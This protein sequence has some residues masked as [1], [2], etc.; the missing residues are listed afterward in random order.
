VDSAIKAD[1]R[2]GAAIWWENAALREAAFGN[3][4]EALQATVTC[5]MAISRRVSEQVARSSAP[6]VL[7]SSAKMRA[8]SNKERSV[9][10]QNLFANVRTYSE[11]TTPTTVKNA[12]ESAKPRR[13]VTDGF[14]KRPLSG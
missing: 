9:N 8:W 10:N 5:E 4:A 11:P 7:S 13:E 1:R 2:E 6:V 14:S 3:N 12:V